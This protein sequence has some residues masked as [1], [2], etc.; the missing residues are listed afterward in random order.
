MKPASVAF[1]GELADAVELTASVVDTVSVSCEARDARPKAELTWFLDDRELTDGV[2]VDE[3]TDPA[4]RLMT[5]RS[6]LTHTFERQD[7]GATLS[8]QASHPAYQD[9]D[10]REASLPVV[11]Q[12]EWS[13]W[14]EVDGA[15]A[16]LRL[17]CERTD[18]C[19]RKVGRCPRT[20][21]ILARL[22]GYCS[23]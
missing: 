15:V 8:C 6:T 10:E 7:E 22:Y 12:C 21:R 17:M 9:Q 14:K 18:A 20:W 13:L 23:L 11:V 4:T 3:T 5:T 19:Y 16:K 2:V 1:A